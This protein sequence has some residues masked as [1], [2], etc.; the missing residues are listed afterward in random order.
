MGGNERCC[1]TGASCHITWILHPLPHPRLNC[2]VMSVVRFAPP[3]SAFSPRHLGRSAVAESL[4][5]RVRLAIGVGL[6]LATHSLSDN[7]ALGRQHLLR[8]QSA[9][10]LDRGAKAIVRVDFSAALAFILAPT[11]PDT[12]LN[13]T[14]TMH[15]SAL[16]LA[17]AAVAAKPFQT[18]MQPAHR[19][20][21]A[22]ASESTA[23]LGACT[24]DGWT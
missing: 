24:L 12:F 22:E 10:H 3:A 14:T 19:E 1:V 5:G 8:T 2:A 21:E 11:S 6:A 16:V 18:T 9:P 20:T 15:I 17:A 4:W 23:R 13:Y 7:Q